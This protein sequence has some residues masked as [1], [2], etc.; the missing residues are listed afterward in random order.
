[1]TEM[2]KKFLSVTKPGVVFGNLITAAGGYFLAAR[3][4]VDISMLLSTLIGITLVVASGCVFNNCIDRNLD[5]KMIRTRGRVLAKKLMPVTTAVIYASFLGMAG[6]TLLWA[7]TNLLAV[8]IVLAG[9]AIYVGVYSLILKRNCV[10]ASLVGSLAGAA[11]PLAGYCAISSRFDMGAVILLSI[12]SLWQMPHCY[13]IAIFRFEDY[14]AASLPVLPVRQGLP[15]VKSHIA[16]Y[17]LAFLA[18]ALMLTFRGYTGYGFLAVAAALGSVWLVMALSGYRTSDNRLWGKRLFVFSILII[19]ALSVM[20]SIDFTGPGA[21]DNYAAGSPVS[22]SRH[23]VFSRQDDA[24][25][26]YIGVHDID[27]FPLRKNS[28]ADFKPM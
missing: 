27:E 10:Y 16:G 19:F 11:P 23:P 4:R 5:Q 1:M 12:F 2:I 14:A 15:A 3:G 28:V 18:A 9:F 17:I 24:E 7:A 13:A 6:I 26:N 25:G 21:S 22:R 20:M 8:A